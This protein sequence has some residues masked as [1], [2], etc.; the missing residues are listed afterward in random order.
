[1]D[2]SWASKYSNSKNV[3]SEHNLNLPVG[4]IPK[5]QCSTFPPT[6]MFGWGKAPEVQ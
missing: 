2:W 3:K 1:M 4:Q 5:V 6:N